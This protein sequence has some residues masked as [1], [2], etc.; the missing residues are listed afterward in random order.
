MIGNNQLKA[1]RTLIRIVGVLVLGIGIWSVVSYI[2]GLL[3]EEGYSRLNH[4]FI[5]LMTTILTVVLLEF[6]RKIDGI[7]WRKLGKPL[8]ER[9]CPHSF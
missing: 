3:P 4:L 9:M 2:R 8:I 1:H 5:V 7:S 6:A